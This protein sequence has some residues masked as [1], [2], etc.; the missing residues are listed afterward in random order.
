MWSQN[1]GSLSFGQLVLGAGGGGGGPQAPWLQQRF[2][3][4]LGLG[5]LQPFFSRQSLTIG[6]EAQGFIASTDTLHPAVCEHSW[7]HSSLVMPFADT[8]CMSSPMQ[9]NA[10]HM[11]AS[12]LMA[13]GAPPRAARTHAAGRRHRARWR[14]RTAM[15]VLW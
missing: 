9:S 13:A 5:L 1:T 8:L 2:R 11:P 15:I 10:S 6:F 14:A 4:R 7:Q 3:A 12:Q